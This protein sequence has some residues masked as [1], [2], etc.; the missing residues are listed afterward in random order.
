VTANPQ[1]TG[2]PEA[3][4]LLSRH[5]FLVGDEEH[6]FTNT[7]TKEQFDLEIDRLN[8]PL[9]QRLNADREFGKLA[10]NARRV[11]SVHSRR[12]TEGRA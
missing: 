10:A 9:E 5:V 8:L 11:A 1:S 4:Q 12:G 7:E 2:S 3:D 6:G